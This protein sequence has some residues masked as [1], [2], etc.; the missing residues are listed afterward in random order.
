MPAFDAMQMADHAL[1]NCPWAAHHHIYRGPTPPLLAWR[2]ARMT[3]RF[4]IC[5]R[6]EVVAPV[7][8]AAGAVRRYGAELALALKFGRISEV[9]RS[10]AKPRVCDQFSALS[11]MTNGRME[12]VKGLGSFV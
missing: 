5:F 10:I 2:D 9:P 4:Q 1:P 6:S 7:A 3:F 12:R 11:M 8:H